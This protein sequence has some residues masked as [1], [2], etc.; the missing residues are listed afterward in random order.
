ME[1]GW[2]FHIVHSATTEA[3]ETPSANNSGIID[4]SPP[5]FILIHAGSQYKIR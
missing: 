5:F 3:P 4:E 1:G 2:I